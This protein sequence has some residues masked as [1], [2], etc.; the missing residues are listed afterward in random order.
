MSISPSSTSRLSFGTIA[1]DITGASDLANTLVRGGMSTVLSIG[2]PERE[3][4]D[5]QAVVV[6]LKTRTIRAGDA[7]RRPM[8]AYRWLAERQATVMANYCS[9]FDSTEKGNVGPQVNAVLDAAAMKLSILCPAFPTNKGTVYKGILFV[10]DV[11][12]EIVV[13]VP[14]SI[15]GALDEL[16]AGGVGHTVVDALTDQDL[17]AIA[18]GACERALLTG[19][20]GIAIGVPALYTAAGASQ[21]TAADSFPRVDGLS[22]IVAG[23]CSAAT[24]AQVAAFEVDGGL[25][26]RID[27]LAVAEDP[28]RVCTASALVRQNIGDRPILIYSTATPERLREVQ[29]LLGTDRDATL[30]ENALS[31]IASQAVEAGRGAWWLPAGN[32]ECGHKRTEGAAAADRTR[33]RPRLAVDRHLGE[34]Q[35]ALALKSDLA[36]RIRANAD[37]TAHVQ[38]AGVP[39]RQDTGEVNDPFLFDVL[40]GTGFSGFIGC[41]YRPRARTEDGPGWFEPDRSQPRP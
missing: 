25:A 4:G 31:E 18:Q 33:D 16:L 11:P 37:Q 35:I 12:W 27:P 14:D 8:A 29:A 39:A 1:D 30:V 2:V 20:S 34:R 15:T 32:V 36:T 19:R 5:A 28:D 26:C 17:A 9:T 38:I 21:G 13:Q 40:D 3:V 6:A 22:L 23:S 24:N 41:E 10:G 7:V